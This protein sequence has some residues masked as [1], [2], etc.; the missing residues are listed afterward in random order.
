[1]PPGP[2]VAA[3]VLAAGLGKRFRSTLPKLLH[4]AAGRPLIWHVLRA[5]SRIA[6]LGPLIVVVGHGR[7]QIID[8]VAEWPNATFVDQPER[9]GTGDAVRRAEQALAGFDGPVLVLPGDH[10]LIT[11]ATLEALLEH[12]VK[13]RASATL[14]SAR[15]EDPTG[16]GRIIRAGE[17]GAFRV[18]EEADASPAQRAVTEVSTGIW[19]FEKEPLFRALAGVRDDNAQGEYYLPDA[20]WIIASE[21]SRV[22]T[23]PASDADEVR[24]VNDRSQLAEAGEGLRARHLKALMAAGVTI[25]DPPATYIDVGVEVGQDTVIRPLTFLEGETSI[26]EGCLIGP[27]TRIVSSMVGD[28]AEVTFSVVRSCTIG[29]RTQVGPYA[30]LRPG[31]RLEAR[32]KVGTFVEMKESI[33]GEGSKVPHLSYMGDAVI[34]KNVNVGAGS[35]TCNY[36]GETKRKSAT[37]IEDGVLIGSDTMLVAPVT[38]GREAVTGASAVVTRDIAPG[39]AVIGAPARPIRRRRPRDNETLDHP[40]TKE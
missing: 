22:D 34:G 6:S 18:V 39:D 37:V 14:L 10:P 25:E 27:C 20:V 21:G 32:S 24:G 36:D 17:Q 4:P 9:L 7:Q 3:V 2:Q 38:V 1:M 35:I 11:T 28:G 15:L 16:Y 31:T 19:C 12:H 40:E 30:S 33:L 26:G 29:P 8:A 5:T 23:V 13:T